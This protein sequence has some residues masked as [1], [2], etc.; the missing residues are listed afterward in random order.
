M[1]Q[2]LHVRLQLFRRVRLLCVCC[3]IFLS[4]LLG[5]S[6]MSRAEPFPM[7][8]DPERLRW[9]AV[10]RVNGTG[11]RARTG[12]SGTLIAP[13]LVVTAA[14]CAGVDAGTFRE[15]HFVAGWYRG[16]FTAHRP[17]FEIDVHPLYPLTDGLEQRAHD[18]AVIRLADPIPKGLVEPVPLVPRGT[19]APQS[20]LLLGYQNNR[21]H[22]LSG[23][24]DCP[25]LPAIHPDVLLFACEVV[26]GNSGGAVIV[27]TENGPA[28][29]GVLVARL[30]PEG[31][32]LAVPVSD[33]LRD[34]LRA[35][36]RR[37]AARH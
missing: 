34:H 35:A 33:W 2:S 32:A 22:V 29:A 4:G 21:P 30:G 17:S 6:D 31:H 20:A 12:C 16:R 19:R 9:Q 14:H 10:G 36:E 11:F 24:P 5:W 7:L 23:R 1:L 13:D 27:E 28:L 26:G 37:D 8:S 25:A 3:I 18:I 15:R